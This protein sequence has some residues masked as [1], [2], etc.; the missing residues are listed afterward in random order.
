MGIQLVNANG[1]IQSEFTESDFDALHIG[2]NELVWNGADRMGNALP[3]GVYIYEIKILIDGQQ[4]RKLGKLV[5]M[6]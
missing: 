3:G 5:L 2:T 6:R 1:Q 4:T